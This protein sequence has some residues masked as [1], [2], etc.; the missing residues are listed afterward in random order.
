MF[1]LLVGCCFN[2]A[3]QAVDDTMGESE[4]TTCP[5]SLF[6]PLSLQGVY[7]VHPVGYALPFNLQC[8]IQILYHH[9]HGVAVAVSA[10][11]LAMIHAD[12]SSPE[13]CSLS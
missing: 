12:E 2:A 6:A 5:V 13:L 10:S 3:D 1:F 4:A 11:Q 8:V 9:V 7:P